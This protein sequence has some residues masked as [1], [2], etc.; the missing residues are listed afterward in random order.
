M[1]TFRQSLGILIAGLLLFFLITPFMQT[2]TQLQDITFQIHWR[3]LAASFGCILVYRSFYVWPFTMLLRHISERDNVS[4]RNAF[5]LF[6]L[7]N[8]TRYLPGKIWGIVRI[9]SLSHR[10]GLSKTAVGGSLTL[11]VGI[12]TVL[13]GLIAISLLLSSQMRNTALGILKKI[14]GH[15]LLLTLATVGIVTGLL[16]LIPKVSA[17]ARH[18]LKTLR[19][20][21][22]P[23]CQ[24]SFWCSLLNTHG[25]Q[26]VSILAGH[27]LLWICQGLAFY[28][29]VRSLVPVAW[30]D[31][32]ILTACYAFAWIVGFLSFLTPSGLGIREGILG[33][34]LTNYISIPQA[35]LVALLCRVW[36]LSAEITLASVAFI[37]NRHTKSLHFESQ[38]GEQ[39]NTIYKT[40]QTQTRSSPPAVDT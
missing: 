39:F 16:F 21:G 28:L 15:T 12:E 9:L 26:A 8:I 5:T 11:H 17:N 7:A 40:Q 4:F 24:K 30:T 29:F 10:F 19:D 37:L 22:Q 6:H 32:S 1:K 33:L 27:L 36:V 13:G 25:N 34:L 38:N 18:A 35:T 31:A 3:W 23:L 14:S 2:H 20:I